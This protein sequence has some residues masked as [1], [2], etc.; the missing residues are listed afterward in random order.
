M[1][2]ALYVG[3]EGR[4]VVDIGAGIGR[5]AYGVLCANRWST[6]VQVTAVEINS[7]YVQVGQRLLPEAT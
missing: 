7:D 2:T 3:G 4:R 6:R 1:D 5:L